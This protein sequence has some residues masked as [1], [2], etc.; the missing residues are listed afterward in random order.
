MLFRIFK[1]IIFRAATTLVFEVYET[2]S[3][4]EFKEKNNNNIGF[5]DKI[6]KFMYEYF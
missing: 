1:I 6:L 4:Y 2:E 5:I 3:F